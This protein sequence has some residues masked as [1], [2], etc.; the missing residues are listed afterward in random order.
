MSQAL[1]IKLLQA[2]RFVL[3]EGG[4]IINKY[5]YYKYCIFSYQ[6]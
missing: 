6:Q 2:I 5:I 3:Q 1:H 4:P